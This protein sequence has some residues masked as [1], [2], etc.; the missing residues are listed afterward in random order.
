MANNYLIFDVGPTVPAVQSAIR[1]VYVTNV[2]KA[3]MQQ[4]QEWKNEQNVVQCM[5]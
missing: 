2:P 3:A 5:L 1:C 4:Q